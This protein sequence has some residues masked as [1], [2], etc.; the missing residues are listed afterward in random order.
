MTKV[1]WREVILKIKKDR[2]WGLKTI[3]AEIDVSMDALIR[4]Q[5]GRHEPRY[6]KG[7][8]LLRLAGIDG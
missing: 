5:E 4:W 1:D 7:A 3:A 2:K 6:S 8:A